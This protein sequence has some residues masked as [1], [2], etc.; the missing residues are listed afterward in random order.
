MQPGDDQLCRDKEQNDGGDVEELAQ[1]DT[2]AAFDKHHAKD[3]GQGHAQQR[4]QKAHK[5]GGVEGNAGEDRDGLN[6][7]TEDH[8]EHEGK[9]SPFG[10]TTGQGSDFGFDLAL[11]LAGGTHHENHHADDEDGGHQHV[12]SFHFFFFFMW[13]IDNKK[14]VIV[15]FS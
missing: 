8:E 6:A 1:I 2:H 7:F 10:S 4:A 11:K 15:L 13:G 5:L 9:Q 12:T 3:H 14:T